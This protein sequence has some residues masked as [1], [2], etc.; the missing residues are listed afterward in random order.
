MNQKAKKVMRGIFSMYLTWTVWYLAFCILAIIGVAVFAANPT[1][2]WEWSLLQG[3]MQANRIYMLVLGILS[4]G[5]LLTY[6]VSNGVTRRDYFSGVAAAAVLLS[7]F[8]VIVTGLLHGAERIFFGW[9]LSEESLGMTFV[10]AFFQLIVFYFVGWLISA[11]FYLFHW[12]IGLVFIAIGI[13]IISIFDF[14]WGRFGQQQFEFLPVTD[15]SPAVGMIISLLLSFGLISVMRM[16]TKRAVV[17][18]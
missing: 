11:G 13:V 6:F 12:L 3:A 7:V 1:G 2:E 18:P 8:L 16:L 4:M 10:M 5:G 15:I 14:V 9:G 17:K